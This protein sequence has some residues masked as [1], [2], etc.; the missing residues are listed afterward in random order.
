MKAH[1]KWSKRLRIFSL[2]SSLIFSDVVLLRAANRSVDSATGSDSGDCQSSP[3]KTI[4]YALSQA[5]ATDLVSVSAGTYLEHITMKEGVSVQGSGWDNTIIDGEFSSPNPIV[6]FPP[7]LTAV[8]VLS[9]VKITRGG[10]DTATGSGGGLKVDY[11]SP[12]IENTWVDNCKAKFGGGVYVINGS[13]V[14]NNVPVWN[15]QAEYG[16]G[17]HLTEGVQVTITGDPF[18]PV[19]PTNGTILGNSATQDGGGI[20]VKATGLTLIGTR[21]Y[22]N[23]ASGG[24]GIN[25]LSTPQKIKIHFNDISGN[26]AGNGGGIFTYN[27]NNLEIIA[28]LV[29]NTLSGVGGNTA[30]QDGGGAFFGQSN[31][32]VQSNFFLNN[33]TTS[34]SGGG[35]AISYNALGPTISANAF[36]GNSAKSNG[37]GLYISLGAAPLIDGNTITRNTACLG[38][39][40]YLYQ[41]G[42]TKLTNNIIAQNVST[43]PGLMGGIECQESPARIINNTIADNTGDGILFDQVRKHYHREQYH[44]RA[45]LEMALKGITVI[46]SITPLI[47][48]TCF[49]M[50]PPTKTLI[51]GQEIGP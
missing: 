20:F 37:A 7:G 49:P 10:L 19:Y 5:A 11:S 24:G 3:C 48:T 4:T 13:P 6:Y 21:I 1:P 2:V 14:F 9:G 38:G 46:R 41:T 44:F 35:V 29:G 12:T 25:V 28:N 15:C 34:G 42:A 51:R 47:I 50:G 23:T 43:C 27:S 26:S 36:D 17:F 45:I 32:L 40:F 16:G 30:T 39:G 33:K 31:G 18:D 22:G 8:T